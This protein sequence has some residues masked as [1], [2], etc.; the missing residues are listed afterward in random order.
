MA[1]SLTCSKCSG[2]LS[3]AD[4]L[5]GKKI[6][7]PKCSAILPVPAAE[8]DAIM[9]ETPEAEREGITKAIPS[10]DEFDDEEEIIR[11]KKA[12]RNIR[13]DPAGDAV[14]T[15]IPYK[16]GRALIA[17]Y[18]GVFSLIPCLGLLLGPA[19][20]V[21]GILGMRYVNANP[22]AKGTG[23]AIAGIILG[24]LTTLGNWGGILALIVMGGI[25]SMK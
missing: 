24:G 12:A 3:V 25:A 19:A 10:A 9:A 15:I 2:K 14:S 13:R 6:K 22:T 16:N 17:Y 8:Q 7:C 21:L 4:N 11:P 18:L 1:I 5:A 20:L 23:H